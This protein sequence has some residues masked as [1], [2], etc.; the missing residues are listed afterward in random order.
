MAAAKSSVLS[1][2][3]ARPSERTVEGRRVFCPTASKLRGG[4]G[5]Q[6]IDHPGFRAEEL[7][8]GLGGQSQAVEDVFGRVVERE[9]LQQWDR[10]LPGGIIQEA[11]DLRVDR[12]R[13]HSHAPDHIP[14]HLPAQLLIHLTHL[15]RIEESPSLLL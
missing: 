2:Q 15:Y 1:R 12:D 7:G 14:Y 9:G 8:R 3:V 13:F 6:P 10:V 11:I 5:S 4:S